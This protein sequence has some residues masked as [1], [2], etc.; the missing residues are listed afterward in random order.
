[1]K[2]E[3]TT[4]SEYYLKLCFRMMGVLN[5]IIV[6]FLTLTIVLTQY[7]IAESQNARSFLSE[8]M[9]VPEKPVIR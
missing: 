2:K 3:K 6:L 1:M 5:F 4:N 7:R 8:L 9:M